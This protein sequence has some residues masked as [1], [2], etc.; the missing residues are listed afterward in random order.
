MKWGLLTIYKGKKLM[1][2]VVRSQLVRDCI[3]DRVEIVL[4]IDVSSVAHA[5]RATEETLISNTFS[6]LSN[7]YN[8]ICNANELIHS[9]ETKLR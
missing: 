8:F 5:M 3:T 9:S 1:Q 6:I 2:Q 7:A 4:A